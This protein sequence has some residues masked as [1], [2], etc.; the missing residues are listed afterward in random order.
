MDP[1]GRLSGG[2]W[3]KTVNLSLFLSHFFVVVFF[4]SSFRHFPNNLNVQVVHIVDFFFLPGCSSFISC[5]IV[6]LVKGT[7][8]TAAL[9]SGVGLRA[10]VQI[11]DSCG[12]LLRLFFPLLS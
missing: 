7:V 8:L 5:Y 3:A 12:L 9:L 10:D 4:L 2:H 11:R 6:L 1:F